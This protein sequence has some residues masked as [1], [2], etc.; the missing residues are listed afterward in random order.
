MF[1]LVPAHPG[2][3]VC[4]CVCEPVAMTQSYSGNTVIHYVLLVLWM[5]SCLPIMGRIAYFKYF[6]IRAESYD[7]DCLVPH[8]CVM[9]VYV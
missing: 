2:S 6:S 4:V 3:P 7:Y 1:L 9:A 8:C 5:M